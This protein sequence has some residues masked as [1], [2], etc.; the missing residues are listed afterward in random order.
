ME[1]SSLLYKIRRKG[2]T[3]AQKILPNAFLSK[4]YF[5]VVLKKKLN[6]KNPQTFNEKLQWLKL[7]YYPQNETV[8]KCAD[9]YAV[10]QYITEKGYGDKLVPLLGAW[11]MPTTSIGIHCPKN[12]F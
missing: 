11:E 1:R 5:K 3:F 8:I 9:K 6:L 12:L 10:R 2:Q 7:Y 4:I